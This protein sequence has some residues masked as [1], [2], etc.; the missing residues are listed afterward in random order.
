MNAQGFHLAY[1]SHSQIPTSS[2]MLYASL[3]ECTQVRNTELF[4]MHIICSVAD[5]EVF[6]SPLEL[7]V[8]RSKS[9]SKNCQ[10]NVLKVS[11]VKV[12]EIACSTQAWEVEAG[13][14]FAF[15]RVAQSGR[16]IALQSVSF[17]TGAAFSAFPTEN[18]FMWCYS[19]NEMM[20]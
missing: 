16:I 2:T 10:Q 5:R 13:I 11:K 14:K 4:F 12:V 7:K 8:L 15:V 20:W 17:L 19:A 6:R 1:W 9:W 18:L 3:L